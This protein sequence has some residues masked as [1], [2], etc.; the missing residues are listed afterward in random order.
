MPRIFISYR[1]SDSA[2]ASS[3]I[4]EQLRSHFGADNV[5]FDVR[6]TEL[7]TWEA[8]ITDR[9]KNCDVGIIVIG[10][11]WVDDQKAR[12]KVDFVRLEVEQLLDQVNSGSKPTAVDPDQETTE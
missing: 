7:G 9:V 3:F 12:K 11:R 8:I 6:S 1:R 10:D 2:Y 4:A 5:F